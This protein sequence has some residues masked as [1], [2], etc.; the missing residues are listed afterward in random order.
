MYVVLKTTL[1]R[2]ET[3]LKQKMGLGTGH[4]QSL[5]VLESGVLRKLLREEGGN[6]C[7]GHP[8]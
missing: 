2:K 7:Q 8:E 4:A 3:M 6:G 1:Q 5:A